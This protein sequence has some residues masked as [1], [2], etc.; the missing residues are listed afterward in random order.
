M[1]KQEKLNKSSAYGMSINLYFDR[2]RK[3]Q[4][5]KDVI[6]DEIDCIMTEKEGWIALVKRWAFLK[7]TKI[8]W[9][10]KL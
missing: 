2:F 5:N 10:K 9:S 4:N 3:K 7:T 8:S 6:W 1:Q